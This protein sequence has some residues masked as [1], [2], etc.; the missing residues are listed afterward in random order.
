MDDI[1]KRNQYTKEQ[2]LLGREADGISIVCL[3]KHMLR[4][5]LGSWTSP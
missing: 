5:E 1:S 3:N 4:L 2:R